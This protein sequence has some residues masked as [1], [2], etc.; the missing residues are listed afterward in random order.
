MSTIDELRTIIE[1]YQNDLDAFIEINPKDRDKLIDLSNKLTNDILFLMNKVICAPSIT[2]QN[3]TT[4][5]PNDYIFQSC[6]GQRCGPCM[7]KNKSY[8]L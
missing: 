2:V 6:K 7:C 3:V 4:I 1:I 5:K 8:S